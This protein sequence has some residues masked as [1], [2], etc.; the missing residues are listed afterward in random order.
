MSSA[1]DAI[2]ILSDDDEPIATTLV[3]LHGSS[4]SS[5][6]T[7]PPSSTSSSSSSS[8]SGGQVL[9]A[10][11]RRSDA[12]SRAR[13][14]AKA[15][16]MAQISLT[17]RRRTSKAEEAAHKELAR[18]K[19]A[20]AARRRLGAL[21]CAL[22]ETADRPDLEDA[23]FLTTYPFGDVTQKLWDGRLFGPDDHGVPDAHMHASCMFW[24][25]DMYQDDDT[26]EWKQVDKELRRSDD[27]RV[28]TCFVCGQL[29]GVTGCGYG[30]CRRTAHFPCLLTLTG[31]EDRWAFDTDNYA[32]YCPDHQPALGGYGAL[33]RVMLPPS[34]LSALATVAEA[35]VPAV[36]EEE[37]KQAPEP[38]REEEE[39]DD[40]HWERWQQLVREEE[41]KFTDSTPVPKSYHGFR[42]H[43]PQVAA[44]ARWEQEQPEPVDE[45]DAET[46]ERIRNYPK[47]AQKCPV[48]RNYSSEEEEETE[49]EEEAEEAEEPSD[50]ETQVGEQPMEV[51]PAAEPEET[52]EQKA[53]AEAARLEILTSRTLS[54]RTKQAIGEDPVFNMPDDDAADVFAHEFAQ[55]MQTQPYTQMWNVDE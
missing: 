33:A 26:G 42:D 24:A 47:R 28:C 41:D 34:A 55:R 7:S 2:I 25:P 35:A 43:Y 38:E 22:C 51:E 23:L 3:A 48:V 13:R 9:R 11:S 50:N 54:P 53:A 30:P 8:S 27:P 17:K 46:R 31:P 21:E 44:L 12:T 18:A 5:S 16:R 1:R 20:R 32:A 40:P 49:A 19:K 36:V 39:E 37:K 14:R 10:I 15:R 45:W 52:P 29:G 6:S 4:S